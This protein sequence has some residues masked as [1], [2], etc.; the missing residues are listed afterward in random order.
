VLL[1]FQPLVATGSANPWRDLGIMF[2][3]A[4]WVLVFFAIINSS[5]A[6][7]NAGATAASRVLYS[8]GRNGVIPRAFGRTHPT[9]KTPHVAIAFQTVLGLAV[10]L[11]LGWK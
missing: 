7:S 3:G 1:L 9:H 5:L 4:G 2:W 6:N 8:L 10:A 11:L